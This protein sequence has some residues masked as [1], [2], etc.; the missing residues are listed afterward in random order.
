MRLEA[1]SE[2]A[3]GPVGWRVLLGR[4]WGEVAAAARYVVRCSRAAEGEMG[5][6]GLE[7]WGGKEVVDI[8]GGFAP[9]RRFVFGI[10]GF[11]RSL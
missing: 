4:R 10:E 6:E 1:A 9:V 5:R 8:F 3:M 7:W 2:G 11:V